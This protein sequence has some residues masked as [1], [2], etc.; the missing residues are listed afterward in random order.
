MRFNVDRV[1]QSPFNV[2][3]VVNE[4]LVFNYFACLL[5]CKLAEQHFVQRYAF[6]AQADLQIAIY[7]RRSFC[8][9]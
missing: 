2:I 5:V 1:I 6:G 4:G 8:G 7:V 3:S 9:L